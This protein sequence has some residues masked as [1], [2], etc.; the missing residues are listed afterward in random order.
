VSNVIKE[1]PFDTFKAVA[2][3]AL[4]RAKNSVLAAFGSE[5]AQGKLQ[6]DHAVRDMMNRWLRFAAREGRQTNPETIAEFFA[7]TYGR[8]AVDWY[9]KEG[10]AKDPN[11]LPT[12]NA[13][14]QKLNLPTLD[15]PSASKPENATA[16]TGQKNP[17]A[18]AGETPAKPASTAARKAAVSDV[19]RMF[20]GG[21]GKTPYDNYQIKTMSKLL[22]ATR[23][24]MLDSKAKGAIFNLT[25][26]LITSALERGE[27]EKKRLL[28][29][30]RNLE[31]EPRLTQKMPNLMRMIQ[32]ANQR[33]GVQEGYEPLMLAIG[34]ARIL[35]EHQVRSK[36][37]LHEALRIAISEREAL[38]EAGFDRAYL[39]K[40]FTAMA[41]H[42]F[43]TGVITHPDEDGTT[44][45][46]LQMGN[47]SQQR[48]QQSP[49]QAQQQAAQQQRPSGLPVQKIRDALS[50]IP[51][52]KPETVEAVS[53]IA[54]KA[55]DWKDFAAQVQKQ[56]LNLAANVWGALLS[57][58]K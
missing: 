32:T 1:G 23:E 28:T 13:I 18:D 49:P 11:W 17:A 19:M 43:N 10:L 54:S 21:V 2:G 31:R 41:Q 35:V 16:P 12:A 42:L 14:R 40:L 15:G 8:E 34:L 46:Q 29:F 7:R 38:W 27:G 36:A 48:T 3:S 9:T 20:G 58:K 52:L 47:P 53:N 5:T 6:L 26:E 39:Q 37:A 55:R 33:L 30:L 57:L 51:N 25:K 24:P 50:K 44:A 56:K 22:A 45:K 4:D